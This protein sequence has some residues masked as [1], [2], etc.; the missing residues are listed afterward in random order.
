MSKQNSKNGTKVTL[1]AIANQAGSSL[2]NKTGSWRVLKPVLLRNRCNACGICVQYC[3]D[4]CIKIRNK[5]AKID[6]DYCKGCGICAK[7]CPVKAII[8]QKEEKLKCR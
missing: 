4:A 2:K 8:M 5:K 3:P 1:G 6:Y 7:E